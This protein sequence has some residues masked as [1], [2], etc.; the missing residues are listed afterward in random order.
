VR[1]RATSV[2]S[3]RSLIKAKA[4]ASAADGCPKVIEEGRSFYTPALPVES[5]YPL[6]LPGGEGPGIIG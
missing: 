2:G 1:I 4:T 3:R 5:I 6:L